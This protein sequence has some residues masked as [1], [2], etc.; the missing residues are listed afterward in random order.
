[1]E[2]S[3]KYE[4][5][6]TQVALSCIVYPSFEKSLKEQEDEMKNNLY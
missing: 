1:M 3:R 6:I 4:I 2:Y 5:K